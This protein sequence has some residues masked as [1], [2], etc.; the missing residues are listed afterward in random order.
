MSQKVVVYL[1]ITRLNFSTFT[2]K[3]SLELPRLLDEADSGGV[4]LLRNNRV[5]A[6][7][8]DQH[9]VTL[10]SG[11][12]VT[13]DCCLIATGSG[14]KRIPELELCS[15]TGVDLT[16]HERVT[17]FRNLRDYSKLQAI[18]DKLHASGGTIAIIGGGPLGSEL[19]VSIAGEA[20]GP[21]GAKVT[22]SDKFSVLHFVHESAPLRKLLPPSLAPS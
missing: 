13:Y 21:G 20:K 16:K 3:L 5:T 15:L 4:A 19:A 1:F 11:Q 14:P 6:L 10:A 8:P 9:R 2:H 7:D 12:S 18:S 22:T 17:Y